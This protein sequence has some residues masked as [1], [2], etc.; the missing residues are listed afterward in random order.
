MSSD[1]VEDF[2]LD[3]GAEPV[4]EL[5]HENSKTSLYERHPYFP[6]HP[7]D[8]TV[9]SV[10]RQLRSVKPYADRPKLGL[11]RELPATDRPFHET[12]LARTTAR[13]FATGPISIAALAAVLRLSAGVTRDNA[14]TAYPRPFRITPSGGALY[15]LELYVD[16]GRVD[17]LEPGLYHYDPE[18]HEL[19]VLRTGDELERLADCLVQP[20]LARGAAAAVLVS[21]VF[22]RSTVK[23]GDRGYRFVL[24]EAGHLAQNALLAA[25]GLGIGSA[26]IGGYLDRAVDRLIGV[27]GVDESVVY[28][29]LF[30]RQS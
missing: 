17:G 27:D 13:S 18:D 10:M 19:D 2:L 4:W 8:A 6:H 11:P 9:V 1:P 30:G 25:E 16:A 3:R 14:D 24:M 7:S 20:E 21:A 5:F 29:L 12:M 26:P 23:Y 15:P 22:F 28:V